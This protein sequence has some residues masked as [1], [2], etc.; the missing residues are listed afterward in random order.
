MSSR[1]L[2]VTR[3]AAALQ[4]RGA[5]LRGP[6]L[7]RCPPK[8]SSW[9]ASCHLRHALVPKTGPHFSEAC[10]GVHDRANRRRPQGGETA[11]E[12]APD[13]PTIDRKFQFT[14]SLAESYCCPTSAN[15]PPRWVAIRRYC[16]GPVLSVPDSSAPS[17]PG[18]SGSGLFAEGVNPDTGPTKVG[19]FSFVGQVE[20]CRRDRASAIREC[21]H[22]KAL[23]DF[24]EPAIGSAFARHVGSMRATRA[25]RAPSPISA[26]SCRPRR[27]SHPA[28]RGCRPGHRRP[29]R[30]RR[31]GKYFPAEWSSFLRRRSSH[32]PSRD[33]APRCS[34]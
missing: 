27:A 5:P 10:Q 28:F 15:R 8:S 16:V 3:S 4:W 29:R 11:K 20:N 26:A 33:C 12:T 22:E 31:R 13:A 9:S 19:P 14:G 18:P 2:N 34:R 30:R 23:P 1:R 7:D 17:P 24:A 6:R 25:A 32:R 21:R